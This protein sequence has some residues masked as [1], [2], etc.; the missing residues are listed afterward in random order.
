MNKKL[1]SVLLSLVLIFGA[2]FSASAAN[3]YTDT[4]ETDANVKLLMGF[5]LNVPNA[6][7]Y[8]YVVYCNAERSYF[9]VYGSNFAVNGNTVTGTGYKYF[10]Y[11]YNETTRTWGV[12]TGSGNNFNLVVSHIVVSNLGI[13]QASEQYRNGYTDYFLVQL[14][15]LFTAFSF[16]SLLRGA[17]HREYK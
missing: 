4:K 11:L 8:D 5:F 10:C 14:V 12:Q 2:C 16:I 17:K 3:T 13:G 1:C 9:L 6:Y 7:N 15:V